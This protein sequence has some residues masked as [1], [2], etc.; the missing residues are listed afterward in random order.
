MEFWGFGVLGF[1]G[2]GVLGF[3]G[4]GVLGFWGFGVL[5][6]WG[7]GGLGVWGLGVWGLLLQVRWRSRGDVPANLRNGHWQAHGTVYPRSLGFRVR[8]YGY[9]IRSSWV[10]L[11]KGARINLMQIY[12][13]LNYG[14]SWVG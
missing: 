1:W 6:F 2:F 13:L 8:L 14:D 10:A 9:G 7:F 11:G 4:F 3:W 5:G 12:G